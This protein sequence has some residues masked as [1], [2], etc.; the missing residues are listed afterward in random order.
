M[1][2]LQG[3]RGNEGPGREAHGLRIQVDVLDGAAKDGGAP[4]EPP[5]WIDE[6]LTSASIGWK[7]MTF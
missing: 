7:S 4:A 1:F 5:Q 3:G 2:E 6:P